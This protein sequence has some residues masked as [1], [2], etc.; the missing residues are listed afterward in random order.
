MRIRSVAT[1]LVACTLLLVQQDAQSGLAATAHPSSARII[2]TLNAQRKANGIPAGIKVRSD[3]ST[4]CRRHDQYMDANN[5][6]THDEQ[7]G[8]P[9]Y[10]SGGAWAGR[11]SVLSY[12][13]SWSQGDVFEESPIHLAQLL[14][15]SLSVSGA[16]EYQGTHALW[17]CVVT[18]AGY[19]R[20]QPSAN[21]IYTYPGNGR[22][23]VASSYNANEL[24]VTPNKLVGA[25]NHC[26]QELFVFAA[27]PALHAGP[28]PNPYLFDVTRATLRTAAGS[29]A[30]VK[31]ADAL[32]KMP[33][34]MGGTQLGYYLGPGAAIVI[35]VKPLHPGT[36]YVASVTMRGN[37]VTLH[38]TWSFT[39]RKA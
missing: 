10:T 32:V 20:P 17:G 19:K 5:V 8:S 39:T 9:G 13:A 35:P 21:R 6:L 29:P 34:S 26:G 27:G 14:Q 3:W 7:Q 37:G 23:G 22:T 24:P 18:L 12:G 11:N 38:H 33:Q 25:P 36:K 30:A 31:V 1:S 16:F 15:P 28:A 2:A 4:D